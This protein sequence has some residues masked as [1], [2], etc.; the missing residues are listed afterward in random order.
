MISYASPA[1]GITPSN[2]VSTRVSALTFFI[3]NPAR[4][5]PRLLTTFQPIFSATFELHEQVVGVLLAFL[6]PVCKIVI[7]N[8]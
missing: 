3:P 6:Q 1:L 4:C 5:L 8:R 7:K 2:A